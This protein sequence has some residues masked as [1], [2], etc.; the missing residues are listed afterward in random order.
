MSCL[1]DI[2]IFSRQVVV[3]VWSCKWRMHLGKTFGCHHRFVW[4]SQCNYCSDVSFHRELI[5]KCPHTECFPFSPP[6]QYSPPFLHFA[7]ELR[8]LSCMDCIEALL[9]SGFWL[10]LALTE[11]L[12]SC[13]AIFSCSYSNSATFW[14][15]L[16]HLVPSGL[17]Y[18]QLPAAL[19][20]HLIPTG[21]FRTSP[22]LRFLLISLFDVLFPV[23]YTWSVNW[24]HQKITWDAC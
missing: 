15:L 3:R 8:R 10:P 19:L 18:G 2:K 17:R 22:T 4:Y 9:L 21:T 13:Q 6:D 14:Q 1:W 7:P 20:L 24:L 11:C 16:P 5:V 12:S 23:G